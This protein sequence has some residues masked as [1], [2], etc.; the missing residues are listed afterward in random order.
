MSKKRSDEIEYELGIATNFMGEQLNEDAKKRIRR[1]VNN[2]T[3]KNW[4][5]AFSIILNSAYLS[6]CTLWQAV[7]AI[8]PSFPQ[9]GKQTDQRGRVLRGWEYAPDAEIL[10]AAIRYAV[11]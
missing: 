4:N 2:P 3:I 9:V 8:D 6:E 10:I 1:V 11:H 7:I 5:N